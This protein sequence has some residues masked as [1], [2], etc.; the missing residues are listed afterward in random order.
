MRARSF[1]DRIDLVG[2]DFFEHVPPGGDLYLVKNILHDWD[3][4][5]VRHLLGKP[6]S[7][8][9][10][11]GFRGLLHDLER[12]AG[13]DRLDTRRRECLNSV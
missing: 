12:R 4:A 11:G 6:S 7:G 13:R 10:A 9:G 1:G 8:D 5:R 2:G 3:D